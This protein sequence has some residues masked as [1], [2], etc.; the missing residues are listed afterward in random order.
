MICNVE[1]AAPILAQVDTETGEVKRVVVMDEL[2]RLVR[3]D[4]GFPVVEQQGAIPLHDNETAARAA[5][6]AETGDWP[7]WEFGW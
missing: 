1:Y 2:V 4:E 3:N 7:A 5:T 6:I